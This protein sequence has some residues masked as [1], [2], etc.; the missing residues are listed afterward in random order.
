MQFRHCDVFWAPQCT[1]PLYR[2]PIWLLCTVALYR[3][4]LPLL[5]TVTQNRYSTIA[6]FSFHFD[7][8]PAREGVWD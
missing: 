7:T 6:P 8:L 1:V 3:C 5:S 2:F 4:S